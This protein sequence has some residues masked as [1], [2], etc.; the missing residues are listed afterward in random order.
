MRVGT[1]DDIDAWI[2]R[3]VGLPLTC[4]FEILVPHTRVQRIATDVFELVVISNPSLGRA[5]IF[6]RDAGERLGVE[7]WMK[8][9]L[10][11]RRGDRWRLTRQQKRRCAQAYPCCALTRVCSKELH[12]LGMPCLHDW[13]R[14]GF[15]AEDDEKIGDH[16]HAIGI[17]ELRNVARFELH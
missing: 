16:A 12:D 1:D 9:V 7:D 14:V 13:L 8:A 2:R 10:R 17:A 4:Q 5:A 15:T 3:A 11:K 6:M